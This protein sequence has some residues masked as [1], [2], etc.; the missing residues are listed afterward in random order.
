MWERVDNYELDLLGFVVISRDFT[1]FILDTFTP[2]PQ[3]AAL[4]ELATITMFFK[5][6]K[7]R[8]KQGWKIGRILAG[9]F[10]V[11]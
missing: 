7:R 8:E 10:E 9:M 3:L 2:F 4:L 5:D 6:Y 11:T 1:K